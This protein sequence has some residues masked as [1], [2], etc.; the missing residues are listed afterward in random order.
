VLR[1]NVLNRLGIYCD[2]ARSSEC[3]TRGESRAQ[4]VPCARL[5]D[6]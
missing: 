4:R 1:D 6:D 3:T 2:G 5:T